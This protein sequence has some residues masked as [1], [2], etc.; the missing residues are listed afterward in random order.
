M[1]SVEIGYDGYT[2]KGD[3]VSNY[4]LDN[5]SLSNS[6]GGAEPYQWRGY[7]KSINE[8]A[9]KLTY[10]INLTPQDDWF[11]NYEFSVR[12]IP[13]RCAAGNIRQCVAMGGSRADV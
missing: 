8:Q 6:L 11:I 10:N 3:Q 12:Q 13:E 4:V 5:Y 9:G 1:A 2:R 7:A